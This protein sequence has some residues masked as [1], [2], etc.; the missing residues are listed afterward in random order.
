MA[1]HIVQERCT[2]CGACLEACPI[3]AVTEILGTYLVAADRCTD[4]AGMAAPARCIAVCPEQA[5][6]VDPV[7]LARAYAVAPNRG[8]FLFNGPYR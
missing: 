3:G 6:E 4:C 8:D 7:S 1:K 2:R 5:I